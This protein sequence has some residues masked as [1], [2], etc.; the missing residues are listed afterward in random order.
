MISMLVLQ[1]KQFGAPN[2]EGFKAPE[3]KLDLPV[4]KVGP[5]C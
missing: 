4:P 1:G 3:P 5:R 2:V